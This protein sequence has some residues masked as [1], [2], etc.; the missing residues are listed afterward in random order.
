MEYR[1]LGSSGLEVSAVGLG[2]NTFGT[3]VEEAGAAAILYRAIDLGINFFDTANSYGRGH[4]EEMIGKALEGG[5]RHQA[6]IATKA[7]ERRGEGPNQHGASR[8]NL[9]ES[10]EVSLR[11]LR[12]DYVDLF[13]VHHPD[14]RTPTEE[15]MSA[16]DDIVRQGKARYVGC[17]NY[18]AWFMCESIWVSRTNHYTPFVSAQ[19]LYNL[20]TRSIERDVVPFC[21]HYGVGIIPYY[22]LTAGFLT[23]KYRPGEP[24]PPG[25]RAI[26]SR[27]SPRWTTDRNFALVGPLTEFAEKQ[28]HAV[29][30]L[31]IAWLL[32]R[33]VV[34]SVITGTTRPE[35]VEANVKAA[36]WK[37]TE[38]DL[39]E[40]EEILEE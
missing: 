24:P 22:P 30:E 15:T 38:A 3:D 40:I 35:Q 26:T 1:R 11:R 32:A 34:S 17:S 19:P 29:A 14:F 13:Q 33:P 18:P 31:A 37:L 10:L 21:Q 9:T 7:S 25:T 36:E 6:L 2:C 20:L 4:S 28:G 27:F 39:A 16:L 5:R 8:T 23:G 12:T